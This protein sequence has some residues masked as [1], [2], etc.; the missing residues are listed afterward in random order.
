MEYFFSMQTVIKRYF[1]KRPNILKSLQA[2]ATVYN[3]CTHIV[4]LPLISNSITSFSMV[5]EVVWHLCLIRS[6]SEVVSAFNLIA[7]LWRYLLIV[8]TQ[9]LMVK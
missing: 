9:I 7:L 5:E 3:T 6:Q 4:H 1:A 2:Q 8:S